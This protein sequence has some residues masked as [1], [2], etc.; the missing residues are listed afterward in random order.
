[1]NIELDEDGF[2]DLRY[3]E[4]SEIPELPDDIVFLD[5]SNNNIKNINVLRKYKNLKIVNVSYNKLT[6][7][8]NIKLEEIN[9]S[10]NKINIIKNCRI[11][12]LDISYNN[13]SETLQLSYTKILYT[14]NNINLKQILSNSVEELICNNCNLREIIAPKIK[15]LNCS[16]NK[17][18]RLQ[19]KNIIELDCENNNIKNIE[20]MMLL[21]FLS[22]S[23]NNINYIHYLP[24]LKSLITNSE[25]S[26]EEKY[27]NHILDVENYY[28]K[29]LNVDVN[30]F[31]FET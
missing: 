29:N 24:K 9:C 10:F 6:K 8:E 15:I 20:N 16:N 5:I 23:A 27:R 14:N 12:R 17:I 11:K 3:R 2:V 25:T 4:L 19:F 21:E 22:C 7:L 28:N 1:M 13:L 31:V 26:I 30:S 18:R